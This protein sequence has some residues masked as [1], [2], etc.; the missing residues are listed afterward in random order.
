MGISKREL[1]IIGGGLGGVLL[2][3]T[4]FSIALKAYW[5]YEMAAWLSLALFLVLLNFL[6]RFFKDRE[7]RIHKRALF[8][9]IEKIF[10]SKENKNLFIHEVFAVVLNLLF[11]V[12]FE[13]GIDY[14]VSVSALQS[15]FMA[16]WM[17]G[18]SAILTALWTGA[19]LF[20]VIAQFCRSEIFIAIEKWVAGVLFFLMALAF[21]LVINGVCGN[22]GVNG[23]N[24]RG[25]LLAIEFGLSAAFI[26]DAWLKNPSLKCSKTV[27]Y[28]LVVAVIVLLLTSIDDYLPMNLFGAVVHNIPAAKKFSLTHRILIYLCFVIPL[29]YF[30]L[31]YPF[32]KTHRR[33]FLTFIA[34]NILFAYMSWP[35]GNEARYVMWTHFSSWPLHLCNTAMYI[36]PLTLIFYSIGTFYFTM[37]INVL[38]AF[39][40]ITMPNYSAS[41]T[42][43]DPRILQF[44]NNHIYA[45]MMPVLVILLGVFE[46]PKWKYFGYSMI[47]FACYYLFVMGL[48]TYYNAYVPT[49][50]NGKTVNV[51]RAETDF[52]FI[53]SDYVASKFA[54]NGAK[55]AENLFNLKT[56]WVGGDGYTYSVHIPYLLSYFAVY[57]VLALGMWYV[58][59]MLF[60]ATDELIML[61]E[62]SARYKASSFE[63]AKAQEQRRLI[64]DKTGEKVDHSAHLTIEHLTKRYGGA[65]AVAVNDFSLDLVGGKI[66]GFLGKNGAG[67][68]TIIKSIVGMHGFNEGSISVCGYDVTHEPVQAKQQ[69]GFVPDNYALYENLTGRQYINYMADLYGVSEQERRERLPNLLKRLEMEDHFDDQMKTYSHGMKQKITIIGALIHD[70]KIWILDEPM[71]GVDP[72]SIFQ[73]KECMREHAK[74]GNI[75]FFSSHLIDVVENLCDEIIIIK[76]GQ[77]VMRDTMAHLDKHGQDLEALF[78]EKTADSEEEAKSLLEE[79]KKFVRIS[80]K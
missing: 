28:A 51:V 6:P 55:W 49:L 26:L 79:Q 41:L 38:G 17:V 60:K 34:C 19:L 32:D 52:F 59:E 62:R 27:V 42:L 50:I 31:L 36:M 66:Y 10:S 67:K 21:P 74:Q 68:S 30:L 57:V 35:G 13:S 56:T 69:I 43:F 14:L 40:A 5:S 39:L 72:N 9:K 3:A 20:V 54:D 23:W 76:H 24:F 65:K 45:F 63:F 15:D 33:A 48:N 22:V 29:I 25:L 70:P 61:H 58:Y 77:F 8:N 75:V 78:L 12:R 46:R 2:L 73:I 71:T 1:T 44:Y 37:F 64:M 47:G 80:K 18:I 4:S 16:P 7:P 11:L 53:Q